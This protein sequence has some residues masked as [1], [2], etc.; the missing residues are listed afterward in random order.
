MITRIK[1]Y[2]QVQFEQ[3]APQSRWQRIKI[4]ILVGVIGAVFYAIV[5]SVINIVSYPTLHLG[6]NW[7]NAL[8][9]WLIVSLALAL[10]GFIVGWPTEEVKAI[11][12]GGV[13]LTVLFLL[14]NTILFVVATKGDQSYFQVLVASLPM[15]GVCVL[16]ALALR[17][18]INKLNT[19]Q[20][21]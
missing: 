13:I 8:T 20:K 14:V 10:A 5:A 11:V 6:V 1:K 12:G 4:G 2:F 19:A 18:V 21:E 16:L 15:V 17:Q 7:S 3:E 9:T